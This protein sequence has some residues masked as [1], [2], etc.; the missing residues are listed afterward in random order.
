MI[1]ILLSTYNGEK[2][3]VNQ[4]ESL[5][6]QT[7]K[8][9][10][11]HIRDDGSNDGTLEILKKYKEKHS[12]IVIYSEDSKKNIGACLS[13]M[14]LLENVDSKYYMFCDQDDIWFPNKI[15][16]CL[17]SILS[18]E[19]RTTNKAILIHTDL[20][21]VDN[22][23]NIISSSLWE[24][25]KINPFKIG[26]KYLK[27]INYVTGCTIIINKL[28]R[29]ISITKN[30]EQLMT[31]E[32]A[33]V[34]W[35]LEQQVRSNYEELKFV[36]AQLVSSQQADSLYGQLETVFIEKTSLEDASMMELQLVKVQ[37]LKQQ[38][39]IEKLRVEQ[40]RIQTALQTLLEIL[41]NL[42][43]PYLIVFEF[44]EEQNSSSTL[45]AKN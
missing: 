38:Q 45:L 40:V 25:N 28:A 24:N 8:E 41:S 30:K 43:Q 14:W 7:Y 17:D 4:L 36:R 9:F 3:L 5:F 2:Y 44:Q 18:E 1:A 39:L 37:R 15:Q 32:K 16:L 19:K 34:S 11:L 31:I 10:I 29:D 33:I 20:I 23:L 13:F 21:V 12:N 35:D 42:H 22:G 26:T 27:V 6:N